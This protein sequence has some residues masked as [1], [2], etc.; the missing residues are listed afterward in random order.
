MKWS[1]IFTMAFVVTIVY[2]LVRPQSQAGQLVQAL[3][4]FG[5]NLVAAATDTA[6]KK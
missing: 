6:K 1:E 4:T 2:V 5:R 3:G